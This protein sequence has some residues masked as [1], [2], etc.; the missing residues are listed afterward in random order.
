MSLF[1]G[2]ECWLANVG[3]SRAVISS[4]SG[5][6]I[7]ALTRD[8]K[9]E[10][11]GEF[12]RIVQGGGTVYRQEVSATLRAEM[13]RDGLKIPLRVL[14]GR[15]SVSRT[16]GDI[17]A[18]S[19][20]HGGNPKAVIA[21]PEVSTA[22]IAD[23]TDFILLGCDGIFDR[24]ST[25]EV[26][27]VVWETAYKAQRAGTFTIHNICGECAKAVLRTAM[28]RGSLDNV[29]AVL[30]VFDNFVRALEQDPSR[31]PVGP[32]A[33]S[34]SAAAKMRGHRPRIS[35]PSLPSDKAKSPQP[36]CVGSGK[37]L[38]LCGIKGLIALLERK[39]KR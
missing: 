25:A 3:D 7:T 8:H 31:K 9:P 23:S 5:S 10:D 19:A 27:K 24:M 39:A 29:T 37:K 15:L 28:E 34:S 1:V 22:R 4:N 16:V 11:P 14:P 6:R 30:I 38:N 33:A 36:Q 21:T 35:S 32:K 18:K 26:G 12:A 20:K 13:G 17:E 2:E